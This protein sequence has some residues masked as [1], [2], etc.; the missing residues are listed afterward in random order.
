VFVTSL[1]HN[2]EMIGNA[3]Y[4]DLVTRGLLWTLGL[5]RDN[6]TAAPGYAAR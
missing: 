5:L 2:N 1:G 4:L 6:G 3:V